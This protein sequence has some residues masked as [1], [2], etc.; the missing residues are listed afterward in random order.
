[1]SCQCRQ[2]Q[3]RRM[4]DA[5]EDSSLPD[6][7]FGAVR[8]APIDW[9]KLPAEPDPD[10]EQLAKTPADVLAILGFDPLDEAAP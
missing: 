4:A 3:A 1:M 5:A 2:C 10:D 7:H 6:V 9:R 8:A